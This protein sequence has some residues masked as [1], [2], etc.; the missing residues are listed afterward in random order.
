MA[1]P[2]RRTFLQVGTVASLAAVGRAIPVIAGSKAAQVIDTHLH[3]FAGAKDARF[4]Y[5]P[6]APY[7]P[8]PAATPELLLKCMEGAG[9]SHAIVV[10]PEPYQDDHRYLEYCLEVGK[11]RLKGTCLVFA[12]QPDS[13]AQL[14]RLAKRG[15]IVAVRVHAYAPDRLPPFGKPELRNLWKRATDLGLAVQLHFEPRYAPGFQPLIEEFRSTVVIIDHLGRPLQGT[16][17]EHAVVIQW[18]RFKNA[19]MKLSAIPSTSTHR[20]VE[21]VIRRL[22]DVYGPDRMIYGGGFGADATPQSYQ[23]ARERAR[24]T[25]AHLSAEDQTK[26]LGGTAAKLFGFAS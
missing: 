24:S 4:P 21:T 19:V 12:D 7:R 23:A 1:N 2:T 20:D 15:D 16:S 22:V 10:H 5:H 6:R 8:E 18:A 11:G 9:V 26:V 14:P 3:C 25:I 13:I 17:E